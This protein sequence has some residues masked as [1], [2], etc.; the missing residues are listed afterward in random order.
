M[1]GEVYTWAV[2]AGLCTSGAEAGRGR[3]RHLVA[4]YGMDAQWIFTRDKAVCGTQPGRRSVGWT[5]PHSQPK[6]CERCET[7]ATRRGLAIR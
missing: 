7:A 4:A 5:E 2:K 3:V 1:T 6:A